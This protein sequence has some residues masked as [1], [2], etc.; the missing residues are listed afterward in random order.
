MGVMREKWGRRREGDL[1][2]HPLSY[3]AVFDTGTHCKCLQIK[4]DKN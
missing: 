2:H 3:V 4:L 1:V